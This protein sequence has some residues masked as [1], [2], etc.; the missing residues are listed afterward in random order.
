MH[1]LVFFQEDFF[2]GMGWLY[3]IHS[4]NVGETDSLLATSAVI[5]YHGYAYFLPFIINF[6]KAQIQTLT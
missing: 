3:L 2:S 5:E 6:N 1:A 4:K